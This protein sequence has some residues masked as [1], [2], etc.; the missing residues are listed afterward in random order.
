M[1]LGAYAAPMASRRHRG[2]CDVP[3]VA[4][5][6]RAISAARTDRQQLDLR[7][8]HIRG[9]MLRVFASGTKSWFINYR[10]GTG[11]KRRLK[12]G[13]Y[14]DLS[15]KGARSAALSALGRVARGEDPQGER[16]ADRRRP[17]PET[18]ASLAAEYLER[19]A[20][21]NKRPKSVR[22]D[23]GQLERYV[24]PAWGSRPAAE[25]T[26]RDVKALLTDLASGKAA[27]RG[28]PT[29]T[30][31]LALRA[32]LS[33]LFAWAVEEE[34]LS[35]N[36]AAGVPLPVPNPPSRDRV[37]SEDEI[38]VLWREL[39]R[40]GAYAPTSAA[41]LRVLLLTAQ[42]PGEVLSMRWADISGAWW[43]VPAG[44]AK[45]KLSH[46]VP[47]VP[48]T[49]A[50]LEEL[51][52]LTGASSWVFESPSRP[53]KPLTTVKT[54]NH[55]IRRRCGMSRWTPHDLRRTVAT[56]LTSG[57]TSRLV[58][59]R[60]LNHAEHG[61]A[62]VYDRSSYDR[63]KRRALLTWSSQLEGIVNGAEPTKMLTFPDIPR[64]ASSE[65]P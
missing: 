40:V 35:V 60:L 39:D 31:P 32:L 24:L 44:T 10:A 18:V 33:K 38:R 52:P 57:G 20:R 5:T 29:T 61:V 42:R 47:L 45:N 13:R 30:A 2:G 50:I 54:V 27:A 1:L 55:A 21:P 11:K 12:L 53:G 15:L 37:L 51:R 58:V 36:P 3:P 65:T 28:R 9:L 41:A 62:A 56:F 4:L 34:I 23:E 19:Y 26:R 43:T 17:A 7:D 59:E 8:G 25:I 64:E 16:K 46:R 63:D 22:D 6:E 14:P 48:S 49:L